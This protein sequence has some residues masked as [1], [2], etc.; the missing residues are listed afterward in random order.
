MLLLGINYNKR[1][2]IAIPSVVGTTKATKF[3]PNHSE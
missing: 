3:A 2:T 1:K